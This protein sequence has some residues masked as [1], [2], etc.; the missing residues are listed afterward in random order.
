M[1]IDTRNATDEQL[2]SDWLGNLSAAF[3]SA[4]PHALAGLFLD[5]AYWRDALAL[6]WS[7]HT[8]YGVDQIVPALQHG[9]S[10]TKILD[11]RPASDP[12]PR[13][14][15]RAGVDVIESFF[16]FETGVGR[17]RGVVRFKADEPTRAWTLLTALEELTGFEEPIGERRSSGSN[18]S[19]VFNGPNWLDSRVQEQRYDDRDPVV[20]VV[21]GGQ[22]GLA[23]AARLKMLGID[24]LIVDR[25]QRIGDNW[26]KR[27]H[28]LALHNETWVNHLPYMPFPDNWPTYIPKDKL[29]NWF[30]AYAESME[31]NFWTDTEFKTGE[32][33]E[34]TQTWSVVLER[35]D[36]TRVMHPRHVIM[37]TGVSGIP[38]IPAIPGLDDFGGTVIH[39]SQFDSGAPYAG[40]KVLVVGSG[41]SGHDVAQDLHSHGAEVSI[42]QRGSTLVVNV[43]PDGAGKAYALYDEPLSTDD[44]DLLT[45]AS[46]YPLTQRSHQLMTE[47][48]IGIERD[49]IEGLRRAG[50]RMGF[51]EDNTGFQLMYLRRGGGYY[52]NVGCTPYIIDGQIK[53]LQ[54]DD[55]A[56]FDRDGIVLNGGETRDFDVVVLA[57]GYWPQQELV[58]RQFG[59]EIADRVGP[60]WGLDDEGEMRNMWQRTA[61]DGM[62]FTAGSLAQ[63][64][65]FS[66][67][68]ALQI[69]AIEEGLMPK[70]RPVDEPTGAVRPHDLS[71]ADAVIT[72]LVG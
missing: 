47:D 57:T 59:D 38:S 22:A 49:Q 71:P 44:C 14:V 27:Y 11:V 3:S 69:K 34:A 12:S 7:L 13:R 6:T 60:V 58:R 23:V 55:F 42:M 30:E 68:L 31:L 19:R 72:P 35:S 32:Y 2:T 51:G 29:A 25:M 33:D 56:R 45:V 64:R 36:D 46:P 1:S 50:F 65:I 17:G 40:Q 48:I 8:F 67:Y 70:S 54:Y 37:A 15:R 66:A 53:I 21:G 24:T 4:D 18:F 52:L 62:W 41:T 26:R 20:L 9:L 28:S 16:E 61:Q 63:C 10:E 39:S 43:G 5:D